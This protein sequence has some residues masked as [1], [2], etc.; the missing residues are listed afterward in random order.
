MGTRDAAEAAMLDKGRSRAKREA[1]TL[2]DVD[3]FLVDDFDD[4][5][6]HLLSAQ[7]S[8]SVRLLSASAVMQN[9]VP[10]I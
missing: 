5:S 8:H 9:A 3:I 10:E 2:P 6:L 1:I 7:P 4:T